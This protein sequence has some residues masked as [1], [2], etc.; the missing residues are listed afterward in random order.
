MKKMQ[1][2]VLSAAFF[3][4]FSGCAHEDSEGT[5]PTLLTVEV[6]LTLNLTWEDYQSRMKA[7]V[8]S[9]DGYR[10]RFIVEVRSEGQ[11]V[12][13]QTV[14]PKDFTEGQTR[15]LLP[16]TLSLHALE[17]TVAVW[18][19]YTD[20]ESADGL[21][22]NA[23]N[24]GNIKINEPYAGNTDYRDCHYATTTLDLQPY[25]DQW[26]A[27]VQ[28]DVDM[29][30]P[31]AKYRIIATD[32]ERYR[33]LQAVGSYPPVEELTAA[34]IY[35]G[36][37]PSS[38]NIA[39]G[40]PNDATTGISYAKSLPAPSGDAGDVQLGSD[41]VWVNGSDSFVTVTVLITDSRGEEVSR[42]PDVRINYRRGCLTTVS[43]NFLT[44]GKMGG[45][46]QVDTDWED[47]IIIEF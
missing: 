5:G 25:H 30:R 3:I 33:Q 39:T 28:L 4:L 17:Y 45:S 22:Y 32:V 35:E 24:F 29:V 34:V 11:T 1:N 20:A 43:G 44:A 27:H 12:H 42:I 15:F 37:V 9:S 47:D 23:D 46:I 16:E 40:S 18:T 7:A 21:Y 2:L 31:L 38:F 14:V 19:D 6:D 26:N 13:R 8:R 10:R 41:M 36:F